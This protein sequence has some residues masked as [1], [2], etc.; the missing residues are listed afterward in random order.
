M[1]IPK[2]SKYKNT[3]LLFELLVRQITADTMNDTNSPA[4]KTLKKYFVNTELGKEYKLYE[5]LSNFQNLSETKSEIVISS[6]LEAAAKLNR[7]EVKKQRYNLIKE[8]KNNYDVEKFFKVKVT[9]YKIYAALNN[10]IENQNNSKITPED[11]INNKI[12]ILEH[13]VKAPTLVAEDALMEEYKAYPKDIKIL[14]YR[15]MLEK[16]NEKYDHFS[17]EQKSILR[18]VITSIDST[19]K[20][21]EY[22][23]DKI[24]EVREVLTQKAN[25]DVDE[26]LK[27]K[28]LEVLKYIN[29][30][31]KTKTVTNDNI[32][33]LL[34]YY[35]LINNLS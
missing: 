13:L 7:T 15:I 10:L 9:N 26:V 14:T 34:Q 31:T 23:N 2:H 12:T 17:L 27:I 19:S 6:L 3:G 16:F 35:E 20:L 24:V 4:T 8:I 28:L 30:V 18:E 32:V 1:A 33:N 11:T 25:A 29:P 22:Y 21:R 5:Q